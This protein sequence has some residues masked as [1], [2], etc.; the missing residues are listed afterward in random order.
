[1][2]RASTRSEPVDAPPE[3]LEVVGHFGLAAGNANVIMQLAR[4]PVGHGVARSRVDS[5]RVDKHPI[6]RL[7]TTVTYLSI[8]LLGTEAERRTMRDEVNRAHSQ[9]RSLPGD[10]VAYNAFDPELQLWVAACLYWGT[11]DVY[12]KL[13]GHDLPPGRAEVFYEYCK[14]LGTT[15]Q[16]KEELWP[17]DLQAFRAYWEDGLRKVQMDELTKGYLQSLTELD[18]LVAPLGPL[19]KPLKP[20]LRP[21]G[22]FLT[23]GWLPEPF[24][25]ELGLP[26]G[27]RQQRLFDA[28]IR[29]YAALTRRS[30]RWSREFPMNAYLADARRRIRTGQ[31]IV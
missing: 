2:N 10:P 20:L 22:R 23:L 28:H 26:W 29:S 13:H 17:S 11:A 19:A 15:L 27:A 4:L 7:R 1:M 25:A 31:A 18:F 30:P 8:A 21:L 6:K 16:V 5:G 24:R 12:R 9:V 3:V 14:R